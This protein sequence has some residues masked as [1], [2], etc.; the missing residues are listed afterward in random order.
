MASNEINHQLNTPLAARTLRHELAI[1]KEKGAIDSSG[2][3]KNTIWFI[4]KS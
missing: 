2:S 4:V 1:L 3:T